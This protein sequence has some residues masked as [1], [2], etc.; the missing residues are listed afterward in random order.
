MG[1]HPF[2]VGLKNQCALM[3][4]ACRV[5]AGAVRLLFKKIHPRER[6]ESADNTFLSA[7]K[8]GCGWLLHLPVLRR[9]FRS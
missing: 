1:A 6:V 4:V 7:A 8:S 9:T 5:A 3:H 2:C